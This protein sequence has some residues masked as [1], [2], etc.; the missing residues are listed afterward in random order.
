MKKLF[1]STLALLLIGAVGV[2][3]QSEDSDFPD[4][5]DLLG[6]EEQP[7]EAA[8]DDSGDPIDDLFDD[9]ETGIV[10]GDPEEEAVDPGELTTNPEPVFRGSLSLDGTVA[11]GLNDWPDPLTGE[12]LVAE[13]DGAPYFRM[14]PSFT[15]DVRPTS[16]QRFYISLA[17]SISQS[18]LSFE[19]PSIAELFADYTL[20]ELYF[21]RVGKQSIAWG[22][23]QLVGNPGNIVNRVRS[24]ISIRSFVPLGPNGLTSVIYTTNAFVSDAGGLGLSAL[25]LAALF[26]A[27]LGE[28]TFGTSFH[29]RDSEPLVWGA[30]AKTALLG[31]DIAVEAV[32][33][34]PNVFD[35]DL[36]TNPPTFQV[37][38]NL[39]WE[40][41]SNP[42]LSI[43]GEYFY[44]GS[45]FSSTGERL[46][47]R[48]LAGIAL[49]LSGI[50]RFSW[51]IGLQWF[52]AFHDGSG[53]VA[54][55]MDG[56][57]APGLTATLAL[58]VT[59]G[60][61]GTYYRANN[62]EPGNR[63]LSLAFQIRMSFSF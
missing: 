34:W 56:P 6:T 5:E 17:T 54:L 49:G 12:S 39:F 40:T 8:P 51:D 27:S 28:I 20:A 15:L 26:D 38:G 57:L 16:Y 13:L 62:P 14:S 55:G 4:P 24:G 44:N 47:D 7:P 2:F 19:T 1:V 58:P 48:H 60:A 59:Y 10:E 46:A 36:V 3:G 37:V 30:Y 43:L 35:F 45:V 61:P 22:Q 9:P 23:G 11:Y 21:F 29:Y 31:M 53:Q 33:R 18:D 32:S 52:H 41:G 63:V 25:G 42:K 50:P